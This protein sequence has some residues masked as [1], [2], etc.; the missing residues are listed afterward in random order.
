M[1]L[2]KVEINVPVGMLS[3][4]EAD[5]REQELYRNALIL[6]QYVHNLT[7]SHGRAAE[8]LGVSKWELIELYNSLGLAYLDI[9]ISEAEADARTIE[10]LRSR[11]A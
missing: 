6:Y 9:D 10:K 11:S 1:T 2:A 4:M 8:I 7:I 3:Y 5:S